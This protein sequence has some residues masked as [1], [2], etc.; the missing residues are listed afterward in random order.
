MDTKETKEAIRALGEITIFIASRFKDGADQDDARAIF[1]K[2]KD[3]VE[4]QAILQAAY[5]GRKNITAE[6]ND[7]DLMETWEL[8]K[9]FVELGFDLIDVLK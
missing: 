7:L 5:E 4:F 8:G 2:L 6:L 1:E 3:D 9:M